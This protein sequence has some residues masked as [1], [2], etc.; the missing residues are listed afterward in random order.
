GFLLAGK[1]L[2][3]LEARTL[4]LRGR[5]VVGARARRRLRA[6]LRGFLRHGILHR[7]HARERLDLPVLLHERVGEAVEP[8]RDR[9][10]D[11]DAEQ[12]PD[13]HAEQQRMAEPACTA[14]RRRVLVV[15]GH[16]ILSGAL[17]PST[18]RPLASTCRVAATSASRACFNAS[19]STRKRSA[20]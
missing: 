6:W 5:L 14:R 12:E 15:L 11:H 9:E 2:V 8:Q 18:A 20:L 19:S 1:D 17:T 4:A 16:H 10:G 13:D 7:A 3:E